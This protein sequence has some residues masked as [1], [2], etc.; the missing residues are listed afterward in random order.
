MKRIF[1]IILAISVIACQGEKAAENVTGTAKGVEDGTLVI[2]S[3]L[4]ENNR[5]VPIDTAT[6]ARDAAIEPNP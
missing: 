5:P 2:V 3:T 4:G 1:G 6:V